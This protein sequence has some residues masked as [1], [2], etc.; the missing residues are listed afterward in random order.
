MLVC[1]DNSVN[2]PDGIFLAVRGGKLVWGHIYITLLVVVCG[3]IYTTYSV[4]SSLL[5]LFFLFFG[6]ASQNSTHA[7]THMYIVLSVVV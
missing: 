3:N 1:D 6:S 2:P 5:M 7:D 4:V